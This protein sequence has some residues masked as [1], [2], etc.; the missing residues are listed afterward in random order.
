M[1][2][3]VQFFARDVHAARAKLHEAHAPAAVKA[4]IELAIAGVTGEMQPAAL[5]GGAGMSSGAC[6]TAASGGSNDLKSVN[7]A[8]PRAR[9]ICGILVETHGHIDEYGGRSGINAF[10]VEPYYD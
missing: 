1:S 9:R 4:L 2:F 3:S 10:R 7:H 8:T 6:I 5:Q